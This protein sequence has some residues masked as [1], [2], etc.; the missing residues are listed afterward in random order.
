MKQ[1]NACLGRLALSCATLLALTSPA[2][3]FDAATRIDRSLALNSE[4]RLNAF[5]QNL[6]GGLASVRVS[7]SGGGSA[8]TQAAG[9]LSYFNGN[10]STT[11]SAI[12]AANL[13]TH[14]SLTDVAN[15]FQQ[16]ASWEYEEVDL[17]QLSFQATETT[18]GD[19]Y[20]YL[21]EI[22]GETAT[23][24]TVNRTL[25]NVAPTVT[26]GALSGPDVSGN[27]T[28]TATLSEDST[29]F[30][31]GSLTLTN[32]T[33][34]VS[35]SGSSYNVVLTPIA[36]GTASVSVQRGG[37]TDNE[38]LGNWVA[39]DEV[40]VTHDGTA[41][42]VSISTSVT[43]V[44]AATQVAVTV[45]FSED[46]TGFGASDLIVANGSVTAV[47]G[48]GADYVATV[49]ATGSGDVEVSIPAGAAEDAAG[50]PSTAS[51][52]LTVS[53]SNIEETQVIIAQF[54]QSRA[55]QLISNQPGLTGFLSGEAT[56]GLDFSA[57]QAGGSFNFMTSPNADNSL[58]FRL[59]GSWSNEDTRE[60]QYVFGVLG[61]HYT[62]SPNLLVGGM[63]EIDY[64]SQD[65]GLATV[66]GS[67]WLAGPYFVAR[68][69]AHPLFFEGRLLYGQTS[70]E[71]SP[72]GTYTDG[73][74]T[75]R[76]LAQLKVA[77]ELQYNATTVIP[78]LQLTYTSDNQ[79]AY[80]DSLD[81]LV[82]EQGIEIGQAEVGLDFRHAVSLH[83]N[84]AA[85]M[86]TGGVAAIG[87]STSGSGNA[88]LVIPTYE[89]GRGKVKLG[90]NYTLADGGMLAVDAFYDGIGTSGY[91]S[92]GLQVGFN[93]A[94]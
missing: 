41:P 52:S 70:N 12:T 20:A 89:G 8:Q 38:G 48:S 76:V 2:A 37:F 55:N 64:F 59:N 91:E 56:S 26:L 58:W 60:T 14:C 25:L 30:T 5:V 21:A 24:V 40:S 33:A 63:V 44:V 47:T 45:T 31:V 32:A 79:D 84:S 61:S 65:D 74:D 94:F 75:E 11:F 72:F 4:C 66:E 85:L 92:Y 28:S 13:E 1:R 46:V 67:G 88:D 57:T 18:A 80:V 10:L 90:A 36:D 71:V 15:L 9:G 3:A 73:F 51:G 69:A 53:S 54:M 7:P 6:N 87:S 82:P 16:G 17:M 78:S 43:S 29:D 42:S 86:L 39:S 35:G 81:N 27:Y 68:T 50:N 19:R 34:I 22:R 83:H 49:V 62:V 93:L 77:G 23:T